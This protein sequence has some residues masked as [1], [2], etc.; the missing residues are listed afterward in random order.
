ASS[1]GPNRL[2][3]RPAI[4]QSKR[5]APPPRTQLG[6][7]SCQNL[8][9][10]F[11]HIEGNSVLGIIHRLVFCSAVVLTIHSLWLPAE[12]SASEPARLATIEW[13]LRSTFPAVDELEG[14]AAWSVTLPEPPIQSNDRNGSGSG[15]RRSAELETS[16]IGPD[17]APERFTFTF[18]A[19]AGSVSVGRGSEHLHF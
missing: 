1:L 2:L 5:P 9:F 13:R 11:D 14:G 17:G 18:P 7:S 10:I 16:L 8:E 3:I 4:H 15:E 6:R 12:S 19:Q